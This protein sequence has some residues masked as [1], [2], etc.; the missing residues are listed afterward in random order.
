MGSRILSRSFIVEKWN[1]DEDENENENEAANTSLGSAMD[2]DEQSHAEERPDVAEEMGENDND[3]DDEDDDEDSSDVAM[4]PMADIL[5]A[6]YQTENVG[7]FR[8]SH[9]GTSLQFSL[10]GKAILREG[11]AKD[12][13]HKADQNWR[14]NCQYSRNHPF[15]CYQSNFFYLV[16]YVWRSAK[17]RAAA[18]IWTRRSSPSSF[19]RSWKSRRC[20]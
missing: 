7:Q 3:E 6:R 17:C 13:V 8:L 10:P 9:E 12:G 2:V 15:V 4:V 14:T 19:W 11:R 16:E 18:A 5:N 20:R 1:E